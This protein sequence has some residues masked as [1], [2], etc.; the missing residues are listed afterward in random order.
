MGRPTAAR[1][2]RLAIAVLAAALTLTGC[3][4]SFNA[5]SEQ[6][7]QPA[8]GV[9]NRSGEVYAIDALVVTNGNGDGTVVCALINEAEHDDA[10]RAVSAVDDKGSA[11]TV[12]PLPSNGVPLPAHQA[13][14]LAT[15]GMVRVN[16]STLRAG[17]FVTLTFT[18]A[19]AAPV[20]VGVPVLDQNSTYAN[21]P[22]G[23]VG[24]G[25]TP[26]P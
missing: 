26:S 18:F 22:V 9:S 6:P 21:V 20:T 11:L 13:V 15:S 24:A 4:A 3:G 8:T 7:Y 14:Q 10:L 2:L 25:T 12:A 16:G 5:Q 23:P 19:Q 17:T 1:R